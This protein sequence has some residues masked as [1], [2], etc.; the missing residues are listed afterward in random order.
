M[1]LS[2][3]PPGPS[4]RTRA[5]GALDLGTTL[6]LCFL[7]LVPVLHFVKSAWL[8]LDYPFELEWMEGG[9]VSH[10]R[11]VLSDQALYR[12]PSLQFT[13]YIYP[14]LYYYVAAVASWLVGPGYMAARLVSGLAFLGSLLLIVGWVKRETQQLPAGVMAA[15]VLA[16]TTVLTGHWYDI[17]RGD[18]LLLLL[19]LCGYYLARFKEGYLWA[20]ICAL[21]L[22]LAF[23]TK[24]VAL[25]L[26]VPP[27]L[28]IVLR[29]WRQGLVATL[30]LGLL[31]AGTVGVFDWVSGGW[32][33]YYVFD[34]PAQHD[35][36]WKEW[37]STIQTQL[38]VPLAP[39]AVAGLACLCRI[40]F[41]EG[42]DKLWVFY[43][44][45]LLTAATTSIVAIL[46][47]GGYP[48]VLIPLYT[49][50]SVALG[51]WAGHARELYSPH[52]VSGLLRRQFPAL[53]M[54][55]QLEL[56]SF[57]Q[58]DAV[59]KPADRRAGDAMLKILGDK[60][61][62]IWMTASSYY[63]VLVGQGDPTAHSQALVDVFKGKNGPGRR[64]LMKEI[65]TAIRAKEYKTIVL[66]RADGF[67]PTEIGREIRKNYE[68]GGQL[69]SRQ[70]P[71]AFWPKGGAA[72]RPEQIWH[73]R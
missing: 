30:L 37:R 23:L 68:Y 54:V 73:P 24:Q 69:M 64:R 70:G 1:S 2:P 59:P 38:W 14:P 34:L 22:A 43:S 10:I 16:A 3:K 31:L 42:R 35:V 49:A 7:A 48:N 53:L 5:L 19:V 18:S 52:R 21:F 17:A 55:I 47:T 11:T 9:I 65:L 56:L 57:G 50:L 28:C 67:L 15:G 58:M 8:R 4:L 63:P 62:P 13:A 36:Y 25:P 20:G 27:L 6:G 46:H 12:E 26:S 39:V 51:V 61:W 44:A 40:P 32:F 29:N 45:W 72:I 41:G 71:A 60:P 66:D 33:T